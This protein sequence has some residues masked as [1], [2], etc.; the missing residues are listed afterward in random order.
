[1]RVQKVA[2]TTMS[3]SPSTEKGYCL[4]GSTVLG[5]RNFTGA[6]ILV[7]TVI[8]REEGGGQQ[9]SS[10]CTTGANETVDREYTKQNKK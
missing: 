4:A 6:S 10:T 3:P 1:M 9:G 8:W 2:G 7:A 5:K